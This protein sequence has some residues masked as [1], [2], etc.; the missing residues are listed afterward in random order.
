[1]NKFDLEERYQ[2]Y[3][4][5]TK[6]SESTMHPTQKIETRRAFY[7]GCGVMFRIMGND[8][9][10]FDDDDEG[11]YKTLESIENQIKDFWDIASNNDKS[12]MN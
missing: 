9:A 10:E 6:L 12:K 2:Q 3:L 5:L 8:V 1:M 11:L 4:K 7:G